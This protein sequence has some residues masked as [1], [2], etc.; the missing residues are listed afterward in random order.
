MNGIIAMTLLNKWTVAP[1]EN[2]L[3]RVRYE[4]RS[5]KTCEAGT[6][7]INTLNY[8][9]AGIYHK[10]VLGFRKYMSK[11]ND[12]VKNANTIFR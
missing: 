5:T 2:R 11:K 4:G 8:F 7:M 6:N 9:K 12:N 3:V 1:R 10:Y